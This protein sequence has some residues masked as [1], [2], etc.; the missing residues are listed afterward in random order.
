MEASD[1]V[2]KC[3]EQAAKQVQANG[4]NI[5]AGLRVILMMVMTVVIRFLSCRF[6]TLS[7]IRLSHLTV[8]DDEDSPIGA[9]FRIFIPKHKADPLGSN[10]GAAMRA[11]SESL[12]L[13][14]PSVSAIYALHDLCA[15]SSTIQLQH[16]PCTYD[17][18]LGASRPAIYFVCLSEGI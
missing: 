13:R 15:V 1:L 7:D 18:I 3:A 17:F 6:C 2:A 8:A 12:L 11:V 16:L 10:G 14:L 9:A 4:N 5:F